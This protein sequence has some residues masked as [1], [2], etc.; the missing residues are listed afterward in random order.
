MALAI[1][2]VPV[3]TGDV[4]ERFVEICEYNSKNLSSSEYDEGREKWVKSILKK[5]RE[6]KKEQK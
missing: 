5:A 6:H 1:S 3:L 2:S 4:A